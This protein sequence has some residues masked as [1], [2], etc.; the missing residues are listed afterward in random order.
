[1]G[2]GCV[3]STWTR[4]ASRTKVSCVP[5][6]FNRRLHSFNLQRKKDLAAMKH[7]SNRSTWAT[8]A[9]AAKLRIPAKSSRKRAAA[10]HACISVS[11]AS[12]PL[13]R[14]CASPNVCSPHAPTVARTRGTHCQAI[15]VPDLEKFGRAVRKVHRGDPDRRRRGRDARPDVRACVCGARVRPRH[16]NSWRADP[17][18]SP[19]LCSAS[20]CCTQHHL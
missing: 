16:C 3:S 18:A 14:P 6:Y 17:R 20:A 15:P 1:M 11:P 12:A 9:R 10:P 13:C 5:R 4:T 8:Q 19:P 2:L 7:C